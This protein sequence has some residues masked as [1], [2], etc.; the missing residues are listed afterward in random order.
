[1]TGSLYPKSG[2]DTGVKLIPSLFAPQ[3][4]KKAFLSGC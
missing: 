2:T 3:F 4:T 1:M